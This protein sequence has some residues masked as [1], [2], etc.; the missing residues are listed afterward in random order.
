[1]RRRHLAAPRLAAGSGRRAS[2]GFQRRPRVPPVAG[3]TAPGVL[4]LGPRTFGPTDRALMPIV[5]RTPDSFFDRGATWDEDRA[6]RRVH[7]VVADGADIVD[8]GGVPAAPGPE[9]DVDE[10]IRRVRPFTAA[11]R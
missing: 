1:M 10:E 8:I 7:A 3:V 11:V 5:N 9:V 4:R 6:M 2:P